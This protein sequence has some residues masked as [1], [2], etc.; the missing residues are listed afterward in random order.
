MTW[1]LLTFILYTLI[2]TVT[3]VFLGWTLY[4]NGVVFLEKIFVSTPQ[5]VKPLNK[6][7]LVGFYMINIGFVFVYFSQKMEVFNFLQ[8]LEFIIHKIGT[9]YL[10]LGGMHLFN[11][12]LFISIEKRINETKK[13]IAL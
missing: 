13:E 11:L 2:A 10:L 7:L 6:I 5:I 8:C 4:K 3:T 12:I 9:V 1:F